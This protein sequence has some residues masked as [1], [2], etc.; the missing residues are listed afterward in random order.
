MVRVTFKLEKD[1]QAAVSKFNGQPADGRTLTVKVVGGVN[2]TIL[3]RLS[4][5]VDDSV[6]VLMADSAS[7]GSYV[8]MF[9][10][11]IV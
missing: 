9:S 1:A 2:A 7:G 3:G 10:F 5:K 11:R 8:S 6:D 4:V